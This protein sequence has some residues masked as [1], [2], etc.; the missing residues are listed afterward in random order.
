MTLYAMKECNGAFIGACGARDLFYYLIRK[1]H[2]TG[3]KFEGGPESELDP[4]STVFFN[5]M[6]GTDIAQQQRPGIGQS[7][8]YEQQQRRDDDTQPQ[9]QV[10]P[11]QPPPP[12]QQQQQQQQPQPQPP[13]AAAYDAHQS[14]QPQNN[15]DNSAED[16]GELSLSDLS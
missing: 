12:P 4:V 13:F 10:V 6:N 14:D 11:Q 7:Y 9:Q 2:V 3:S 16:S 15:G 8:F 5:P 1:G